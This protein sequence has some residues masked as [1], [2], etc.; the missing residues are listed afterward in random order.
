[1]STGCGR[2]TGVNG[3]LV[4]VESDVGGGCSSAGLQL[5]AVLKKLQ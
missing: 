5:S 1:M 2:V 3:N 4:Y